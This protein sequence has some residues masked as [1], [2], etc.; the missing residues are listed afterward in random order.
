MAPLTRVSSKAPEAPG[1]QGPPELG[2]LPQQGVPLQTTVPNPSHLDTLQYD[3]EVPRLQAIIAESEARRVASDA[4]AAQSAVLLALA[5]QSPASTTN[6][7]NNASI[8]PGETLPPLVLKV[9]RE[10]AGVASEDVHDIYTS[11]F[12]PWNLIRL[13]PIRGRAELHF[14]RPLRPR[15]RVEP[16]TPRLLL[17]GATPRRRTGGAFEETLV[18]GAMMMKMEMKDGGMCD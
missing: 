2:A 15:R 8:T 5:T 9:A 6:A 10:L 7:A 12:E 11:K 17:G 16:Q 4:A 1:S 3:A 18:K 13:H 14:G